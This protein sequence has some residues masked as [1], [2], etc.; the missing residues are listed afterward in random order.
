MRLGLFLCFWLFITLPTLAFAS[1]GVPILS[2]EAEILLK[3]ECDAGNGESCFRLGTLYNNSDGPLAPNYFESLVNEALE[4]TQP[5][6]SELRTK[7]LDQWWQ[8]SAPKM[9]DRFKQGCDFKSANACYALAVFYGSFDIGLTSG[10]TQAQHAKLKIENHQKARELIALSCDYGS[11]ISCAYVADAYLHTKPRSLP[12]AAKHLRRSCDSAY[13]KACELLAT[14]LDVNPDHYGKFKA[15][16]DEFSGIRTIIEQGCDTQ[17]RLSCLVIAIGYSTGKGPFP[18][19]PSRGLAMLDL[20]CIKGNIYG[21]LTQGILLA[22]EIPDG[23]AAGKIPLNR[24]KG[25]LLL[26]RACKSGAPHTD[27]ACAV[28]DHLKEIERK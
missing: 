14:I 15:T 17:N 9:F 26:E 11:P 6:H 12:D 4:E 20:A 3:A 27:L 24:E 7:E 23:I 25:Q 13:L 1:V 5:N 10:M 22:V 16:P 19:E 28:L 2:T 8:I 18:L 21:C